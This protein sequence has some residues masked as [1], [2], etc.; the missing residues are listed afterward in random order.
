MAIKIRCTECGKRISVDEGFAG[1]M[2]RCPYCK[3]LVQ[4]PGRTAAHGPR[5]AAPSRR[6][7][8]PGERPEV[9]GRRPEAPGG[10]AAAGER[11]QETHHVPLARPVRFQGMLALIL[12]AVVVAMAAV[13]GLLMVELGPTLLD[14]KPPEPDPEGGAEART[15]SGQA[16]NGETR[17][18]VYIP[19]P[20]PRDQL[21]GPRIGEVSI[22]PPVIYCI[23]T[24]N[25]RLLNV[26]W[27]ETLE[28]LE[29]L[30]AGSSVAVLACEPGGKV[31]VMPGGYV[32]AGDAVARVEAFLDQVLRSSGEPLP[33]AV[34]QAA[35][36]SPSPKT[37]VVFASMPMSDA[38]IEKARAAASDA[39]AAIAVRVLAP[40]L[41]DNLETLADPGKLN[42]TSP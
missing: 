27:A 33:D 6:P 15:E 40:G 3:G 41:A 28:S 8:T 16:D 39:G 32:T 9:P 1:S 23:G 25:N 2:C 37:I 30:P 35:G 4:V 31:T 17:E 7:E 38:E 11:P 42:A 34:V 5:P 21:T 19:E 22:E 12:L 13:A 18:P 36:F 14:D 24:G 20:E 29:T 10:E 26:A